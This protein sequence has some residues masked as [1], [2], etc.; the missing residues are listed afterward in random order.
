MFTASQ[1]LHGKSLKLNNLQTIFSS[2]EETKIF[3]DAKLIYRYDKF[4]NQFLKYFQDEEESNFSF[5]ILFKL[6][7]SDW[8]CGI[9]S[10]GF[11]D[12][13]CSSY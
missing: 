7:D 9:F 12:E 11:C 2:R 1:I 4:N 3:T 6:A 13:K 8:V 10:Q 5:V